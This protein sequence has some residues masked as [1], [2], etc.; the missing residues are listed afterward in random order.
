LLPKINNGFQSQQNTPKAMKVSSIRSRD[1]SNDSKASSSSIYKQKLV[2]GFAD[3]LS[4]SPNKKNPPS[5]IKI[6]GDQ[7]QSG[8]GIPKSPTYTFKEDAKVTQNKTTRF[9]IKSNSDLMLQN[10]VKR[11]LHEAQVAKLSLGKI[12]QK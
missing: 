4:S 9:I 11:T 8:T 12:L 10:K 2:T 7:F 1:N 6:K 3:S 5:F